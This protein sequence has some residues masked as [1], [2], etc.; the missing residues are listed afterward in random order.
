MTIRQEAELL[1][2]RTGLC[3]AACEKWMRY[4][5]VAGVMDLMRLYPDAE[6]AEAMA[7]AAREIEDFVL[8]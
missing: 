8:S 3:A 4:V 1:S 7:R 6:H 2:S 5:G